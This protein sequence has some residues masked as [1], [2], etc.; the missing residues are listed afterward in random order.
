MSTPQTKI[1]IISSPVAEIGD[2]RSMGVNRGLEALVTGLTEYHYDCTVLAPAGSRFELCPVIEIP[3]QLQVSHTRSDD[4]TAPYPV[5]PE[6]CIANMWEYVRSQFNEYDIFL[7][8]QHDWL[9][10]YLMPYFHQKLFHWVNL[11]SI[12]NT[13]D[14]EIRNCQRK[15]PQQVIFK[16]YAQGEILAPDAVNKKVVYQ[17]LRSHIYPF[18][19]GRQE[20]YLVWAGR[21]SPEKGLEDSLAIARALGEPL[22]VAG[23]AEDQAYFDGLKA[24]FGELLHHHGYLNQQQLGELLAGARV[25]L[26]TQKWHEAFGMITLEALACGT[27]VVA[28]SRGANK[29]LVQD[30][31]T[32]FIVTPDDWQTMVAKIQ[33]ID[34]IDP[35]ACRQW[36]ETNMSFSRLGQNFHR[37]FQD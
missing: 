35:A 6:S 26:H 31:E 9:P 2:P 25:F 36:V 30:G 34:Q 21:I 33:D 29:E 16:S 7:N 3:G 23:F 37:I 4:K 10:L 32:G 15:Y 5:F 28:Y 18:K 13:T 1:L 22:H 19:D 27:P 17:G 12:N 24:E 20:G 14:L 8:L 11:T